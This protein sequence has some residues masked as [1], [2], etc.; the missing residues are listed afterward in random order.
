MSDIE[1]R[2][3][4]LAVMAGFIGGAAIAT[5]A[6]LLLAP[7]SGA[8]TRRRI[9][10]RAERSRDALERMSAAAREGATAARTAFTAAMHEEAP[11]RPA[12]PH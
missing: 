5:V 1:T 3:S 12:H 10:E 2:T 7:R 6:T 4:W 8:E 9:A 11:P